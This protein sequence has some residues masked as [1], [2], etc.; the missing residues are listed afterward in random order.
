MLH[1]IAESSGKATNDKLKTVDKAAS[2]D[3]TE[4]ATPNAM[5][6]IRLALFGVVS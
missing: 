3:E 1:K 5:D 2:E 6:Q 4:E